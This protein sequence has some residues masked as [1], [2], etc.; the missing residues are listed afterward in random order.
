MAEIAGNVFVIL[1]GDISNINLRYR[2]RNN[3]GLLAQ[4]WFLNLFKA[5]IA[6]KRG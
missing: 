2:D 1:G 5:Q 3:I 4:Q 6:A